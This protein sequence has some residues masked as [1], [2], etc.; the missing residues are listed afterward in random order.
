MSPVD[1]FHSSGISEAHL[2]TLDAT[3]I[4]IGMLFGFGK[5]RFLKG[6]GSLGLRTSN[7]R[8]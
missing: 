8:F 4:L 5:F 2:G 3:C 6:L 7:L 1:V